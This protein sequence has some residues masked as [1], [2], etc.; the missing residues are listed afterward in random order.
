MCSVVGPGLALPH[1]ETSLVSSLQLPTPP[2]GHVTAASPVT[3]AAIVCSQDAVAAFC[4]LLV[5]LASWSE[6]SFNLLQLHSL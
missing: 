2:C 1:V 5:D 4:S 6:I 3:G